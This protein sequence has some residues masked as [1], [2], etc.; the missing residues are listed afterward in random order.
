M[1]PFH[2]LKTNSLKTVHMCGVSYYTQILTRHACAHMRVHR[3]RELRDSQQ[4]R[5]RESAQARDR[6]EKANSQAALGQ[7]VNCHT[8]STFQLLYF[9]QLEHSL[10]SRYFDLGTGSALNSQDSVAQQRRESHTPSQHYQVLR[11]N[12]FVATHLRSNA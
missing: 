1:V 12:A 4:S 2:S 8:P 11:K 6:T 9:Y 5:E 3:V 7:D 10:F